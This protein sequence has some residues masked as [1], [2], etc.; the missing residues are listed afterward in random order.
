MDMVAANFECAE[1]KFI[2]EFNSWIDT[3]SLVDAVKHI[4][5]N[6]SPSKFWYMSFDDLV[7]FLMLY[8][9]IDDAKTV[10]F[11]FAVNSM[12]VIDRHL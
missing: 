2:K 5:P 3:H 8:L 4:S 9:G 11:Y 10:F 7:C 1:E 12:G 6:I